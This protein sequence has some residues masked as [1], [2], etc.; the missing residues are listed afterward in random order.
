MGGVD[1]DGSAND[2]WSSS[3]GKSWVNAGDASWLARDSAASVVFDGRLWILGAYSPKNDIWSSHDGAT[4]TQVSAA[5]HWSGRYGHI[6]V[7]FKNKIWIL[8]GDVG[9]GSTI[10]DVWSYGLP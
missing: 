6:S 5:D 4:W 7:V 3:D 8:G 9:T 1:Y 2:V 10:N